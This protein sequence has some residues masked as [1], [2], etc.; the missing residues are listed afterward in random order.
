VRQSAVQC[1]WK[2]EVLLLRRIVWKQFVK[3]HCVQITLR[4]NTSNESDLPIYVYT[5]DRFSFLAHLSTYIYNVWLVENDPWDSFSI[6]PIAQ[7]EDGT[8]RVMKGVE[9]VPAGEKM[10]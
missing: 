3:S 1:T 10:S 9:V 4:S 7:P 2:C 8:F 6:L 5:L